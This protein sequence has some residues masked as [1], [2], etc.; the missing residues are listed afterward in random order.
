MSIINDAL[1]L[2]SPQWA[3]K[4]EAAAMSYRNIKAYEAA[5]PSRTHKAQ[6]EGR[7]ANQAVFAAGKSLREQARWLDENHDLS[8]GILD[9][10]EERVVGA[11]GIVVEP[12]PRSLSGEILDE[13]ANDIQ[14]RFGAWSLKCDVTGR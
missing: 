4:R 3:L 6:K 12:Q 13:L 11:Q 7:G 14:R 2:F 8:I 1:A 10:L 9:R 5:K